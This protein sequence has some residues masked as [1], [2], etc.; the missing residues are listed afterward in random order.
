MG[1][2]LSELK[3]KKIQE[4]LKKKQEQWIYAGALV[5]TTTERQ[6]GQLPAYPQLRCDQQQCQKPCNLRARTTGER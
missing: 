3:K 4:V 1:L 6:Q 2:R 5:K